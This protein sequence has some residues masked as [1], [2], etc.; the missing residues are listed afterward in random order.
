MFSNTNLYFLPHQDGLAYSF[1]ETVAREEPRREGLVL[2][3]GAGP[4]S[5]AGGAERAAGSGQWR[6]N[7][8]RC[9]GQGLVICCLGPGRFKGLLLHALDRYKVSRGCLE[10]AHPGDG[11][12]FT[13]GHVGNLVTMESV[14]LRTGERE[15]SR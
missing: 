9:G 11:S 10:T 6:R 2:Q 13:A 8:H 4:Q 1:G 7:A 15:V 12:F 14:P 3:S 5:W